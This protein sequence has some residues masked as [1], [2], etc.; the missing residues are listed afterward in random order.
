[1]YVFYPEE[2]KKMLANA[3]KIGEISTSPNY[4]F[5]DYGYMQH[6]GYG[7]R[8]IHDLRYHNYLIAMQNVK[9][10]EWSLPMENASLTDQLSV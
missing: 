1:M 7:W 4:E 2:A 9:R 3:L 5:I 8:R 10:M 6:S